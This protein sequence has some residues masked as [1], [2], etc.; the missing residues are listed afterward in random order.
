[1]FVCFAIMCISAIF[2]CFFTFVIW[3]SGGQEGILSELLCAGLFETMFTVSG[4]L[5]WV[6]LSG[7][8]DWVCHIGTL[9]PC[10]DAVALSCI[11][12]SGET[13]AWSRR[14]TDLIVPKWPIMC[15]VGLYATNQPYI[16]NPIQLLV[17]SVKGNLV[18]CMSTYS[19]GIQRGNVDAKDSDTAAVR[20]WWT[21]PI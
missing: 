3:L 5:I 12:D 20:E 21:A 6:V 2:V 16:C 19:G 18:S 9:M 10:I 11:I 14:L 15:W 17:G 8:T 1:M 4:T 7:P 13:Q